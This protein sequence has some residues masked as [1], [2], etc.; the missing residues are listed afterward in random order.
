MTPNNERRKN[1]FK[2]FMVYLE[3]GEDVYKV[4]IPAKNEKEVRDYVSGNGD[5]IAIKDITNDYPISSEK[6]HDALQRAGFGRT[7]IDLITRAL[8]KISITD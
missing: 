3:D 8:S 1:M 4:A 6:V 7:E 5:I 2:K